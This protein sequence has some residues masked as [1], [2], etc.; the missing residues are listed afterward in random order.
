MTQS[1]FKKRFKCL[2]DSVKLTQ[3]R[4]LQFMFSIHIDN[5]VLFFCCFLFSFWRII[6]DLK[7]VEKKYEFQNYYFAWSLRKM[8]C[9]NNQSS[10][11]VINW[12]YNTRTS[13]LLFFPMDCILSTYFHLTFS[14]KCVRILDFKVLFF[15]DAVIRMLRSTLAQCIYQILI[16]QNISSW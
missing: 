10:S 15:A 7:D 8:F 16:L 11:C 2:K 9:I 4:I 12:R 3:N 14:F 13:I 5:T 1:L 6:N